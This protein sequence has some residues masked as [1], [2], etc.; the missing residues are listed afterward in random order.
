MFQQIK[1]FAG[2][3]QFEGT[4]FLYFGGMAGLDGVGLLPELGKGGVTLPI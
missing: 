1:N 3:F 2:N 4:H